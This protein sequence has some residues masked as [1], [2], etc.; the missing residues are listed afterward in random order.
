LLEV[1]LPELQQLFT[2][3]PGDRLDLPP[4][5]AHHLVVGPRGVTCVEARREG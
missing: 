3:H 4:Q 5:V 2:L 1:H